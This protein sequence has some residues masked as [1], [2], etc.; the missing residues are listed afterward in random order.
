[1]VGDGPGDICNHLL[2]KREEADIPLG[3][4]VELHRSSAQKPAKAAS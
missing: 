4:N 3:N 2:N 1:V